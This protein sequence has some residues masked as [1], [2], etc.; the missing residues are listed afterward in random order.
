MHHCTNHYALRLRFN[1]SSGLCIILYYNT[2]ESGHYL[3]R[4]DDCMTGPY[5][6]TGKLA[7]S[8]MGLVKI[9]ADFYKWTTTPVKTEQLCW[10]W[11]RRKVSFVYA[12]M[13]TLH[14]HTFEGLQSWVTKSHKH[15]IYPHYLS[16][17]I[18][19]QNSSIGHPFRTQTQHHQP[20]IEL[21]T[22]VR[23]HLFNPCT[24]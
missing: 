14:T 20:W 15:R 9:E 8:K 10:A 24:Y 18:F 16:S 23:L 6:N 1:P 5:H 21:P 22:I 19:V 4:C 17:F 11:W 13:S 7:K 3:Y 2:V 12:H